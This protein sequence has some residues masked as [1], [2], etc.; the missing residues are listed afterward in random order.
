MALSVALAA[1]LS[2]VPAHGFATNWDGSGTTGTNATMTEGTTYAT[3]ADVDDTSQTMGANGG[4]AATGA[5][6]VTGTS[7]T[8]GTG[9]T[10]STGLESSETTT[11]TGSGN[12]AATGSGIAADTSVPEA[13]AIEVVLE[14]SSGADASDLLD[15]SYETYASFTAGETLKVSTWD[16]GVIG[17][18]Y[19]KWYAIP[20]SW[21]L[22]FTDATGV[23]HQQACGQNGFLHEYVPLEGGGATSCELVFTNGATACTLG[24][25]SVGSPPANVQTWDV[26]CTQADF[27]VCSTH[28]DDE[29]LWLGGVLATYAGGR[30]LSTQVVYMTN[31]W[32]GD[33]RR[34]HEKLDGLWSIGVRNYPVN[35]PFSDY[36]AED[37]EYA[38]QI[39][40][41]DAVT[42]F[43]TKEVRRCKPLVVV[44]QDFNGEYGHGGHKLLALAVQGAVDNSADA[45]FNADSAQAFGVWDVPK[46]Y[47]HLYNENRITLDLREP[48]EAL[49]GLTAIEAQQEAYTKHVSQQWTWFYLTDDP[50]DPLTEQ[51]NCSVFGLYRTL[52]GPDTGNDMLENLT[53]YEEQAI[54]AQQQAEREEAERQAQEQAR[55]EAQAAKEAEVQSTQVGG[56]VPMLRAPLVPIALGVVVLIIVVMAIVFVVRHRKMKRQQEL[57]RKRRRRRR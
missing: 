52:V 1:A 43:F 36:Y 47:Y 23:S 5:G 42:A 25:Y 53:T 17:G 9:A 12:V 26:P 37:L 31:Y 8:S 56:V 7:A 24:A 33:V 39:Y 35:A 27:M 22:R 55:A 13:T 38:Q 11:G 20:G 14:R 21:T 10:T 2:L 41:L 46:T 16:G 40:D 30:G 6:N 49:G 15:G 54:Q 57:L 44:C 28:A 32:D 51:L 18:L 50:Y 45:S 19:L 29:I 34:E 3:G 48:I 4:Y